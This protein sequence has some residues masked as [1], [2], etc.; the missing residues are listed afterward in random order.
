MRSVISQAKTMLSDARLSGRNQQSNSKI[1][2]LVEQKVHTTY[3]CG[4]CGYN[5]FNNLDVLMH[6]RDPSKPL[7]NTDQVAA[8]PGTVGAPWP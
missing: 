7:T 8:V 5:L 1:A 6:E 4:Q 2:Q 3:T